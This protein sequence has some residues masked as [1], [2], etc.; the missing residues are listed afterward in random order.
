MN[1]AERNVSSPASGRSHSAIAA[2]S[3]LSPLAE[4]TSLLSVALTLRFANRHSFQQPRPLGRA[5]HA[6]FLQVIGWSQPELAERIHNGEGQKPFTV[7]DLFE[8]EGQPTLR[9]TALTREVALALYAAL[10]IGRTP[11]CDEELT[12]LAAGARIEL[13]HVP[14]QIESVDT[15]SETHP[16]AG[17]ASYAR[18]A[19]SWVYQQDEP[20]SRL[21]LYFFTP[22]T[23]KSNGLDMP[24]PMPAWVFGS[25]SDRWN[26]FSPL[27]LPD[28]VRDF[29][30]TNL[31]M[32]EYQ[33][34]TVALQQ[35]GIEYGVMGQATYKAPRADKRLLG[36]VNLLA[37]YAF[38]AGVG[39]RTSWG[40]GQCCRLR[41]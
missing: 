14:L 10:G 11:A 8:H 26:A 22:T 39:R 30:A 37:E 6:L 7:S 17:E 13:D 12:P 3:H 24:V 27:P 20:Q 28:D 5:A 35:K 16:W 40:M 36:A 38:F 31:A 15:R 4:D 1:V 32:S 41:D 21:R 18:L 2:V 23:F 19:H 29:A 25:L 33:L 9:F 34:G